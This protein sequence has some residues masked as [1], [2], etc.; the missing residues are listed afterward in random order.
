M[1]LLLLGYY[2]K[3]GLRSIREIVGHYA[4]PSENATDA[5]VSSVSDRTGFDPDADIDLENRDD[6]TAIVQAMCHQEQGDAIETV[7]EQQF[8]VGIDMALDI[9]K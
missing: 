5:Y 4:P 7:T 8:N 6:L 9:N 1:A 3:H 2:R